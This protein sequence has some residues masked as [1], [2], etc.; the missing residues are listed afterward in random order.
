MEGDRFASG[1]QAVNPYDS[2]AL[3]NLLGDISVDGQLHFLRAGMCLWCSTAGQ[4]PQDP[5]PGLFGHPNIK[6]L[7]PCPGVG[8]C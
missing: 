8:V 6:P 2:V 5:A 3:G 7:S 4:E 1:V